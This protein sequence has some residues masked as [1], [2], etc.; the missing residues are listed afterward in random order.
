LTDFHSIYGAELKK[1]IAKAI[2]ATK[3]TAPK[4]KTKGTR[5]LIDFIGN[6]VKEYCREQV[7]CITVNNHD[8][9]GL[10]YILCTEFHQQ[11]LKSS[12]HGHHLHFLRDYLCTF[13]TTK[14]PHLSTMKVS[15]LCRTSTNILRN[16]KF[17]AK[18]I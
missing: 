15:H 16:E 18:S 8:H 4:A 12:F 13:Y 2:A 10:I 11:Y 9:L 6:I 3:P 7:G 17:G 14:V 5:K 1:C